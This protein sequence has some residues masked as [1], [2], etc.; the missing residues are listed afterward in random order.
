MP[1]V[2]R[3]GRH[4]T[5]DIIDGLLIYCVR[6]SILHSLH[7]PPQSFKDPRSVYL[8]ALFSIPPPPPAFVS[9]GRFTSAR[10]E[11]GDHHLS[12]ESIRRWRFIYWRTAISS[13]GRPVSSDDVSVLIEIDNQTQLL[14]CTGNAFSIPFFLDLP[15]FSNI[16][17]QF[18]F[19][20][21]SVSEIMNQFKIIFEKPGCRTIANAIEKGF[22]DGFLGFWSSD[23]QYLSQTDVKFLLKYLQSYTHSGALPSQIFRIVLLKYLIRS[24]L[25]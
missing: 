22:L 23:I 6:R 15:L 5:V 3:C 9:G 11:H 2:I 21:E 25:L 13:L 4:S 14:I 7:F 10:S 16:L 19:L 18:F 12:P 24:Y 17:F 8:C 20:S 1:V